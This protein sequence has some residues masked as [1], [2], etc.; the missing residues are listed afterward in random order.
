MLPLGSFPGFSTPVPRPL[1]KT[2]EYSRKTRRIETRTKTDEDLA[3]LHLES[4]VTEVP[5]LAAAPDNLLRQCRFR[6]VRPARSRVHV[7]VGPAT[8]G[9]HRLRF[10]RSWGTPGCRIYLRLV[11]CH[12]SFGIVP[13]GGIV[14]SVCPSSV[15]STGRAGMTPHGPTHVGF[16]SRL[17]RHS[18]LRHPRRTLH[19]GCDKER[20]WISVSLLHPAK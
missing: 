20:V 18:V 1:S 11:P 12:R 10:V 7:G 8:G 4:Q 13:R 6:S 14:R 5:K 2:T 17:P 16:H 9:S 19:R 3:I 15:A